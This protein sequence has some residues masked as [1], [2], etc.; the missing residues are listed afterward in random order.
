MLQI[1]LSMYLLLC[2]L[3]VMASALT[4]LRQVSGRLKVKPV[5]LTR[6]Y[7]SIFRLIQ[8]SMLCCARAESL[9]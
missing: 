5:L 3:T 8:M 6:L 4:Y 1:S 2:D 9:V 7:R